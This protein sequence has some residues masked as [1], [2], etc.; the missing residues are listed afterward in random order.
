MRTFGIRRNVAL[1]LVAQG[2]GYVR[3]SP[4]D[5]KPFLSQL[6]VALRDDDERV[7]ELAAQA[8]GH[9][10]ATDAMQLDLLL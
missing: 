8:L 1:Y 10:G 4:V 3:P 7:N 2:D 9:I 6:V 5:V